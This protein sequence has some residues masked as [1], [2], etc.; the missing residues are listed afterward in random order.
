MNKESINNKSINAAKAI[1]TR[2]LEG[3]D[4]TFFKNISIQ[5]DVDLADEVPIFL[6][7]FNSCLFTFSNW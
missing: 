2:K 5:L 7:K 4:F 3:H 6:L 1:L